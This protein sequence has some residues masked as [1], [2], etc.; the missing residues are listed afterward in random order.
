MNQL[1]HDDKAFNDALCL[2]LNAT[3]HLAPRGAIGWC[4]LDT[5]QQV[6]ACDAVMAGTASTKLIRTLQQHSERCHQLLLTLEPVQG[7][8]NG[9]ELIRILD[10][11]FCQHIN[12]AY[13]MDRQFIDRDWLDWKDSWSGKFNY[14]AH[15]YTASQLAAGIESVKVRRR[16]WVM[17][18]CAADWSGRSVVLNDLCEGF[19]IREQLFGY[20]SQSRAVLYAN[21]Q[22]A[23]MENL[24]DTNSANEPI[25]P[26]EIYE[27]SSIQSLLNYLATEYRCN[28]VV[29]TNTDI[30]RYLLAEELVDEVVYYLADFAGDNP[31]SLAVTHSS[32]IN[33]KGWETTSCSKAGDGCRL[34]LRRKSTTELTRLH[35]GLN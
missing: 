34:V 23:L 18:V 11:S 26:F 28:C 32:A 8:V 27:S 25:T 31:E 17:A 21:D 1:T 3:S 16:P 5:A 13:Q 6:I 14:L 22:V 24:P 20:A 30:L 10:S 2:M 15:T 35:L 4:L 19:A 29:Y 7:F 12:V 9:E 33:F